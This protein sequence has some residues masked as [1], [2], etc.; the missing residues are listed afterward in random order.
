M[1][2]ENS[3]D[4]VIAILCSD[5][6]LS[7]K[8]PIARAEEPDWFDAMARPLEEIKKLKEKHGAIILFAGD[9]FD[10]WNANA[11]VINFALAVLPTMYA[12]PGQ[13]DLPYH[14]Y[15]LIKK[16]AYWTMVE[17]LK[18][19]SEPP[20]KLLELGWGFEVQSFPWGFPIKPFPSQSDKNMS[21][22][23]VHSYIWVEGKSYPGAPKEARMSSKRKDLEGYDV[24][25]FGDNHKGFLTHCG[26]TTVFNCG[27]LMRRKSDEIE[28]TPQVG[29]LHQSGKVTIHELDTSQDIIT[30]TTEKEPTDEDMELQE[31]LERLTGLENS[32]LDF[33]EAVKQALDQK[34]LS[35]A[36]T[37]IILE[38]MDK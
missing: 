18:I 20:R 31:F 3:K 17:A 8:P 36:V 1:R 5:F 25:V 13:H 9:L 11:E 24:A 2:T 37:K 21:V 23:L 26:A 14:N 30:K 33:R 12:I 16:S 19:S 22:A 7:S 34:K 15:D 27:G 38:A 32:C 4:P 28:Y 6:H 10:K 35:K 29:L